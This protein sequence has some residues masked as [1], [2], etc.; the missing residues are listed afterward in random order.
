MHYYDMAETWEFNGGPKFLYTQVIFQDG[1]KYFSAQLP[2][3]IACPDDI[4]PTIKSDLKEIPVEHIWPPL[5]DGLS[6]CHDAEKP[7]VYIKQP[8]LL[9]YDGSELLSVLLL[10]EAR[11]CQILMQN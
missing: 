9:D 6:I 7:G 2:E 11:I 10:Q 5:E 1:N 3:Q 8:Q 4:P